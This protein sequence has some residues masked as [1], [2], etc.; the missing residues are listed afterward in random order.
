M[1]NFS[2]E[3]S[4]SIRLSLDNLCPEQWT[5]TIYFN[6]YI[7]HV[8]SLTQIYHLEIHAKIFCNKLMEILHLLPDII[9]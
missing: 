3:L 7:N 8:L 2:H 6:D 1:I 9:T 5:K 4:K